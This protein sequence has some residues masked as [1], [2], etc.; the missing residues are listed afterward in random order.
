MTRKN[1]VFALLVC[2]TMGALYFKESRMTLSLSTPAF[3]VQT[4]KVAKEKENGTA[5]TQ[6]S[7]GA[8]APAAVDNSAEEW[9]AL[10]G[11]VSSLQGEN[12]ELQDAITRLN[13]KLEDFAAKAN[14][15]QKQ[16]DANLKT[17]PVA[18]N[19]Q[20]EDPTTTTIVSPTTASSSSSRM[21]AAD[22]EADLVFDET[23]GFWSASG[24]H[25]DRKVVIQRARE[26]IRNYL[27]PLIHKDR[28]V[29]CV[30]LH[31]QSN[32]GDT[33]LMSAEL[34]LLEDLKIPHHLLTVNT[35]GPARDQGRIDASTKEKLLALNEQ[36]G[37]VLFAAGGN[38][39]TIYRANQN[40]YNNVIA[41]VPNARV[42]HLPQS[43][44]VNIKRHFNETVGEVYRAHKDVHLFMRDIESFQ[45][46]KSLHMAPGRTHLCPDLAFY[47][48]PLDWRIPTNRNPKSILYMKRAD[49]ETPKGEEVD[50]SS[51]DRSHI[52]GPIDWRGKFCPVAGKFREHANEELR[53]EETKE[54]YYEAEMRRGTGILSKGK[55]VFTDR[56][57]GQILSYLMGLPLI[58]LPDKTH[59]GR[60]FFR[61][62]THVSFNDTAYAD[63]L[64]SAFQ[65]ASSWLGLSSSEDLKA[66]SGSTDVGP[67]TRASSLR[68]T[69]TKGSPSSRRKY[70]VTEPPPG[71][72]NTST[73]DE[74]G[75][76]I[77]SLTIDL[78]RLPDLERT[79]NLMSPVSI[80]KRLVVIWNNPDDAEGA[81]EAEARLTK[82]S[83]KVVFTRSSINSLNNRYDPNLPIET[84]AVMVMDDDF[85]IIAETLL[86]MWEA[87]TR[88]P[89]LIYSFGDARV[90]TKNTYSW[91]TGAPKKINFLLPRMLFH[92][93]YLSVYSG[94]SNAWVRNYVDTQAAHC[95]DI[96]F[97]AIATKFRNAPMQFVPAPHGKRA[98]SG[99]LTWAFLPEGAQTPN[100]TSVTHRA[101]GL[102][103]QAGR[104]SLRKE[105]SREILNRLDWDL[106]IVQRRTCSYSGQG[107]GRPQ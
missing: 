39:G 82:V 69:T 25:V 68:T 42:I 38:M 41:L 66:Q 99:N 18:A 45:L 1:V 62:W 22:M 92:R 23:A 95:D 12:T 37:T 27:E 28:P 97:A 103:Q 30:N 15:W 59:K 56:L 14:A 74:H 6:Q 77:V 64:D 101:K 52:V 11:K 5:A 91:S 7:P 84:D 94:A 72:F 57:H 43:L 35:T 80:V 86:C 36:G 81:A 40:L 21:S 50:I 44:V 90:A 104:L 54:A 61:T 65:Q 96:A 102:T 16:M 58:V 48:G 63:D 3:A 78:G 98:V 19:S 106:P 32:V 83:S 8:A 100:I 107:Q 17:A 79:A 88:D 20:E 26:I 49:G 67:T 89:S 105:C 31:L 13:A 93:K 4:P 47:L 24:Q 29:A 87:W 46:A 53:T 71:F 55:V 70:N 75:V 85:V 51:F 9:N 33:A 76:T 10:K 60:K 73:S 2:L 34:H